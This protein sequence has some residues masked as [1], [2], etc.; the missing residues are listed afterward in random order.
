MIAVE[1]AS[2]AWNQFPPF[3]EAATATSVQKP[4]NNS[5]A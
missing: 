1:I 3:D 4:A 2:A 5:S